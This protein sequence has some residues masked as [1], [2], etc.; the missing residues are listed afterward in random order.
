MVKVMKNKKLIIFNIL[1]IV[2]WL[3]SVFSVNVFATEN[4]VVNENN[5]ITDFN[6]T[7]LNTFNLKAADVRNKTISSFL[8]KSDSS[9][10][11]KKLNSIKQSKKQVAFK[12]AFT[13][14]NKVFTIEISSIINKG[15]YSL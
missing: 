13:S 6:E 1:F 15:N 8:S 4:V 2:F 14:M 5:I 7:F 3:I 9:S 10:I 11:T 12:K